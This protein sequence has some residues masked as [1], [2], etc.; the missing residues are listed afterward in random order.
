[1]DASE[2]SIGHNRGEEQTWSER[3]AYLESAIVKDVDALRKRANL[4]YDT[5]NPPKFETEEQVA[6][7]I[8][9]GV[10]AAKLIKRIG[11][12]RLARTKPLR[13]D[14]DSINGWYNGLTPSLD[15]IKTA[16]EG[17]VN[18]MRAEKRRQAQIAAAEQAR[19]EREEA[20]RLAAMAQQHEGSVAGDAILEDAIKAEEKAVRTEAQVSA[21]RAADSQI[22]S[23][24]GA[25][26]TGVKTFGFRVLDWTKL[27]LN[28]LR[29]SFTT[30]EVEK[31]IRKH[32]AMNKDRIPLTSVEI[33]PEEKTRFRG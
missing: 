13:D 29:A 19:R 1:M 2:P 23:S 3:L 28:Q 10:D 26:A 6:P 9:I 30:D 33:F 7:L 5:E 20:D 14:V 15:R 11:E 22:R 17:I 25:M 16:F 24:G 31:A 12:A 21:P 8:E 18:E 4:A 27:D 32:V